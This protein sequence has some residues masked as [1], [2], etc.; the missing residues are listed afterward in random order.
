MDYD[1]TPEEEAQLKR[2]ARG[3]ATNEML[4]HERSAVAS[5]I[6]KGLLQ[7]AGIHVRL[8][9]EGEKALKDLERPAVLTCSRHNL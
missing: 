6:G 7:N 9:P 8:T 5:L 1:L 3:L 4:P 2:T